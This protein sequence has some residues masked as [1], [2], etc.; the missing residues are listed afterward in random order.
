MQTSSALSKI[1]PPGTSFG[2]PDSANPEKKQ[3]LHG[4]S[5]AVLGV[6]QS[7]HRAALQGIPMCDFVPRNLCVADGAHVSVDWIVP[8]AVPRLSMSSN[9]A[10]TFCARLA[11]QDCVARLLASGW[12]PRTICRLVESLAEPSAQPTSMR[13]GEIL[14][15]INEML[16]AQRLRPSDFVAAHAACMSCCPW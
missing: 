12:L 7:T 2:H 15:E 16:S 10:P 9:E 13:C 11:S 1:G 14:V 8:S 5:G 4:L 6:L 3:V